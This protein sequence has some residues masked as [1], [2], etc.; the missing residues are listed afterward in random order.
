ML[1]LVETELQTTLDTQSAQQ[2]LG[3]LGFDSL[4]GQIMRQH[5]QLNFNVGLGGQML[6]VNATV[7]DIA[8]EILEKM[9]VEVEAASTLVD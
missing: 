6:L 7:M 3:D 8:K 5:V 4:S 1:S 9:Q 2:S